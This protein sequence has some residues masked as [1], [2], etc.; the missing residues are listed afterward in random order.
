MFSDAGEGYE[1]K[2]VK[3]PGYALYDI[4]KDGMGELFITP[5]IREEWHTYS[6]YFITS[7]YL[8]RF[9]VIFPIHVVTILSSSPFCDSLHDLHRTLPSLLSLL[10]YSSRSHRHDSR[11]P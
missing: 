7:M 8:E 6:V 1:Y 5:D 3:D 9:S 10:K 4:D 2:D 11:Q